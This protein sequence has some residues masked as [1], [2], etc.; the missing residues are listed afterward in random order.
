MSRVVIAGHGPLARQLQ[1]RLGAQHEV[2]LTADFDLTARPEAELA[3]AGAEVVVMLASARGRQTRLKTAPK[4]HLDALL[5]DSVGRAAKLVGAHRVVHFECG[6]DDVRTALLERCGVS[7]SVLRGGGPD[8]VESL[9]ALVE[10][11]APPPP[12]AWS[13]EA[14]GRDTPRWPTCSV[15]RFPL[16]AGWDALQLARAHF[17]WLPSSFPATRVT[18]LN[19]TW[20]LYTGGVRA[21]VLRHVPGRSD[22]A[23]AWFE[24]AAGSLAARPVGRFEFRVLLDGTAVTALI[25]YEPALPFFAYRATQAAV[26][27][28]TMRKFIAHLSA[29]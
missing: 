28:R 17:E 7:L 9:H 24:I 8:P 19:E 25:G 16:P 20:T 2:R 22:D 11:A 15:Q 26:H 10:G 3:L 13:G 29:G 14:P 21:L 18:R 1:A 5:A 6:D 23:C 4:P 27:E 12:S